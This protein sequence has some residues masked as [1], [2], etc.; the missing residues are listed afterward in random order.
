MLVMTINLNPVEKFIKTIAVEA[1]KLSLKYFNKSFNTA[2]TKKHALDIVTKGDLAVNDFLL[3]KIKSKYPTHGI[4]SEETG[5]YQSNSDY[6]WIVDP[7]D[8]TSNFAK[9]IPLYAIIIALLHKGR[10][11]LT[12]VYDPVHQDLYF[13][14]RN[15]GAFRNGKRIKCSSHKT[16]ANS[17]GDLSN[18]LSPDR[19]KAMKGI[20]KVANNERVHARSIFSIAVSSFLVASGREDWLYSAGGQLWDYAGPN[21]ILSE[22]G[23]KVTNLKGEKWKLTDNNVVAAN[24]TLHRRLIK[25]FK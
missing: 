1:G 22:A 15:G 6:V 11:E 19:I 12:A 25:A 2:K 17:F 10:V 3:K 5:E 20:M 4:L 8:G 24:P 14:K 18:R 23:C 16:V 21:L 9:G 7:I 13:A